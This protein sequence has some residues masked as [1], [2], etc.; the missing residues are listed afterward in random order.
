[1]NFEKRLQMWL[2]LWHHVSTNRVTYLVV[3]ADK[4]DVLRIQ[5]FYLMLIY[6]IYLI[7]NLSHFK[8]H[9][10]SLKQSCRCVQGSQH[11]NLTKLEK[12]SLLRDSNHFIFL[13]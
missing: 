13:L 3:N 12:P 10:E 6:F 11:T 1:M 4:D 8:W 5:F 9:N 7:V 2:H